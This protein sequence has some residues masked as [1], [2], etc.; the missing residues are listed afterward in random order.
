MICLQTQSQWDKNKEVPG[1]WPWNL[2]TSCL[3]KVALKSKSFT[4]LSVPLLLTWLLAYFISVDHLCCFRVLCPL[5]EGQW[6]VPRCVGRHRLG[7]QE[8]QS[9]RLPGGSIVLCGF[10]VFLQVVKAALYN[11]DIISLYQHCISRWGLL[12]PYHLS[13]LYLLIGEGNGNPLQYSCLENSRD[14]GA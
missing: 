3:P 5:D 11:R 12:Q 10:S 7:Q 14:R 2:F 4:V 8:I 9:V 1:V 6:W 13:P